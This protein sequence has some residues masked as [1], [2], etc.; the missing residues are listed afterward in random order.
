M[1]NPTQPFYLSAL[2][3]CYDLLHVVINLHHF[4]IGG[5][6]KRDHNFIYDF[7]ST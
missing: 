2:T 6:H 7:G 3:D 1:A 4:Y 5:D